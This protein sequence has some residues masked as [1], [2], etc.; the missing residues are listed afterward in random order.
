MRD[1]SF[2][3]SGSERP[4]ATTCNC[5][6]AAGDFP[7]WPGI[8]LGIRPLTPLLASTAIDAGR[9]GPSESLRLG[10]NY[11]KQSQLQGELQVGNGKWEVGEARGHPSQLQTSHWRLRPGRRAKQSQLPRG[12]D[13]E[14][15]VPAGPS[16]RNK[17]NFHG[18]R[19]GTK[20]FAGK[21]LCRLFPLHWSCKTKPIPG[22]MP[23]GRSAFPEG[24]ACETKP[25][26]HRDQGSAIRHPTSGP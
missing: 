19:N 4:S 6:S 25:I 3:E 24:R 15:G 14:I 18:S 1:D 7:V 9:Q 17:A 5:P 21:E 26:P 13:L 2:A 12:A 22:T 16:V 10:G 11:A 23:I 20:P 8:W